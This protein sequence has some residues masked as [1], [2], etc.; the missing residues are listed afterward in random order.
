MWKKI[1]GLVQTPGGRQERTGPLAGRTGKTTL[2]V[3]TTREHLTPARIDRSFCGELLGV[4]SFIE[5]VNVLETRVMKRV[6]RLLGKSAA[7]GE[8]VPRVPAVIPR[9]LQTM[10]DENLSSKHLVAEL[11]QDVTLVADVI[12]SA[13]SAVY[14]TREPVA[15]LE[16]A[17]FRLGRDG[18]RS[19]V[20][21]AALKPLLHGRRDHF[22]AV[23]APLLWKQAE[24]CAVASEFIAR[25]EGLPVFEASLAALV[26]KVGY[27]IVAR[28][29]SEEHQ[30]SDAP[31]SIAFRDWLIARAPAASWR[32]AAQWDL[33]ASV[34]DGLK[35]L[36]TGS[37]PAGV[38]PLSG[39][40]YVS[41]KLSELQLMATAGR[42]QGDIKRFS[43]RINGEL[44]DY[45]GACYEEILKLGE[46]G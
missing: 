27:K 39:V 9:L 45:C 3:E 20:A 44:V 19:L 10:R 42:I 31:R 36:V 6:D 33:P 41:A 2:T 12:R 7:F 8:L 24:R 5:D 21:R 15:S 11:S 30:G 28:I 14:R 16:Q 43:C 37:E 35:G 22:S 23:A 32:V 46:Q 40:L 26:H 4:R 13:N 1:K 18:L 29:L 25:R 34:T 17:L 38:S